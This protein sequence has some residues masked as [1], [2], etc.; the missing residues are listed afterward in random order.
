MVLLTNR[1]ATVC[2]CGFYVLHKLSAIEKAHEQML[3]QQLLLTRGTLQLDFKI[4]HR[5]LIDIWKMPARVDPHARGIQSCVL[6]NPVPH[7][8][9][10][11]FHFSWG[12]YMDSFGNRQTET[13]MSMTAQIKEWHFPDMMKTQHQISERSSITLTFKNLLNKKVQP[14]KFPI[15]LDAVLLCLWGFF[16]N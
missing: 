9:V 13:E 14:F 3:H 5:V 15:D 8:S 12:I 16:F 2:L 10:L 1:S 7:E 4:N 6:P 11:Q